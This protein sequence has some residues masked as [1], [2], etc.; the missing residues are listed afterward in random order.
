MWLAVCLV[1]VSVLVQTYLIIDSKI[2]EKIQVLIVSRST[3]Y[4][5]KQFLL[6]LTQRS[7]SFMF[8]KNSARL[9][10]YLCK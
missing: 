1:L 9:T 7:F 8:L 10:A 4:Y 2:D 5:I 3:K 6:K